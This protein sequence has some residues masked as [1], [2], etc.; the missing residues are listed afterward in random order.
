MILL[1]PCG[2]RCPATEARLMTT[3]RRAGRI[4]EHA[5]NSAPPSFGGSVGMTN[6]KY[7]RARPTAAS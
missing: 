3:L 5:P 4:V 2:N 7:E 6:D 1:Q